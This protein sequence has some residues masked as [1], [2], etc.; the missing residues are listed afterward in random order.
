MRTAILARHGE[1]EMNTQ[2]ALNSAVDAAVR[3]TPAGEQQARRLGRELAGEPIGFCATSALQRTRQTAELALAG[4][5]V[6]VEAWPELNDPRYGAFEGGPFQPYRDWAWAHGSGDVPPGGGESRQAIV[7]RYSTAF[8]RL[9]ERPEEVVLVVA[10]SLPISYL[11]AAAD[12][13][14]PA[15]RMQQVAYATPYRVD[16]EAFAGAVDRLETWCAAP[17]W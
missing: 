5:D 1:S 7:A 13:A 11:L 17:T 9:L 6:A 14:E 12:G 4:C 16:A 15:R 10:H 2:D 8:R 3:L